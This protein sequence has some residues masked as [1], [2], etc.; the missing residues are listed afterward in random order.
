MEQAEQRQRIDPRPVQGVV[1]SLL[2]AALAAFLIVF[3]WV[4]VIA[5]IRFEREEAVAAAIRDN[6]NRLIAFEQYVIRTLESADAALVELLSEYSGGLGTRANPGH[7]DEPSIRAGAIAGA[8]LV[9]EHGYVVASNIGPIPRDFNVSD[10]A[11]FTIPAAGG[12]GKTYVSQP[13]YSRLLKRDV[14]NITRKI[15]KA[16]GSFGGVAGVG[17]YPQR[18]IDFYGKAVVSAS[19]VMSV[20]GEDGVT[21]VRRTGDKISYGENLNGLLVMEFH[22]RHPNG[23]Y[24]G[25]GGLD[26]VTRYFSHRTLRDYPLFVTVGVAVDEILAPVNARR[27]YYFGGAAVLSGL[28][29]AF[30]ILLVIYLQRRQNAS[31]ELADAIARLHEAQRIANIG[32]WEY[33]V[34]TGQTVWSNQLLAMYGR[35][36]PDGAPS[37]AEILSYYDDQGRAATRRAQRIAIETGEPQEIELNVYLP[38]G[39]IVSHQQLT[40]PTRDSAGKVIRLHGTAQ[41]ITSRKLVDSL[42]SKLTHLSRIDAMNTMAATLAHELNQPLTAAANYLAGTKRI[43]EKLGAE[44]AEI[45]REGL[46]GA[47]KQLLLAGNII[48]RVRDMI[49]DRSAKTERIRISEVI[50]DA[51][52]LVAMSR[53]FPE[54]A[55][56][57]DL[58]ADADL[59]TA[60]PVQI[61]QV[62]INL[63]RNACDAMEGSG[64]TELVIATQ[65]EGAEEV[66]VSIV[67]KGR[68]VPPSVGDLFSTFSTTKSNGLGIGLSI[69]R[70]I[71][72]AHGGQIW[73]ENT[74]REGTT[75][76]FTLPSA[77]IEL[78][79]IGAAALR[80]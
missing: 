23:T 75:I 36:V 42:Q 6:E 38:D 27:A 16:D 28:I 64:E 30:A 21:R 79:D 61:Q 77:V 51:L 65:R 76:C 35:D 69:S 54:T 25:P 26:G 52:S 45:L 11:A 17:I 12:A 60:D 49:A 5:Q 48:R 40:V 24:V 29:L 50:N 70:T 13:I 44:T 58:N 9:D 57:L 2:I 10:R 15:T 39:R 3:I 18:L 78:A 19:D 73:V 20:I 33:D 71:V 62:L 66:R 7:I 72:E 46:G 32:D 56:K 63:I 14:I 74:G 8:T 43:V 31:A 1:P 53:S 80:A 37:Q 4:V 59:V 67:D 47:E 68:G 41:D 34:E 22:K 55:V